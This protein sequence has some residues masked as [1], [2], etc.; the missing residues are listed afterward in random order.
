MSERP[1]EELLDE[2]SRADE[3]GDVG[4]VRY[5]C[6]WVL[7]KHPND[8]PTLLQHASNL[9]LLAQYGL[10]VEALQRAENYIPEE[11]RHLLCSRRA[12]IAEAKG[13][14]AEAE[15]LYWKAHEYAPDEAMYMI[16]AGA[17]AFRD[18]RISRAEELARR[19]TEC[20]KG[21][22]EE[23]WFNL[24]GYL[25]S[26]KRYSE[27]KQCYQKAIELDPGYD[28]AFQRLADVNRT[29]RY[30]YGRGEEGSNGKAE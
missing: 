8:W 5:L 9:I 28:V 23:A 24:G 2:L 3:E 22:L 29:L 13:Q 4:Y 14:F 12:D 21:C 6:E 15:A 7:E 17:V 16:F 1:N 11:C 25:L 26:Q 10:A 30:I 19:A 18:G 20:P 27:A